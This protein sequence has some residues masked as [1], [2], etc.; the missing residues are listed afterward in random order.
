[1]LDGAAGGGID[2]AEFGDGFAEATLEECD[3]EQGADS[4]DKLELVDGLGDEVVGTALNG[5]LD[6]GDFVE[7]C[8]HHDRDVARGGVLLELGADLEAA[9]AWHHDVQEDDVGRFGSDLSECLGTVGGGAQFTAKVLQVG[10]E[11]LEVVLVIVHE[12]HAA[13]GEVRWSEI[14][15]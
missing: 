8:H 11:E 2:A 12:Q 7:G 4:R 5:T 6:I 10:E 9:H 3:A 15:G 1:M 13:R 14:H